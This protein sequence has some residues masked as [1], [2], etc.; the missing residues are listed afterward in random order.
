MKKSLDF[1]AEAKRRGSKIACL[2]AYDYPTARLLDEAGLDILLVGDSLG[3]VVLGHPDTTRVRMSDMLHH[4]RAVVRGTARAIV[5]ADLP[6][7]SCCTPDDAQKN[8]SLLAEAGA[9]AVKIE[10]GRDVVPMVRAI[11]EAGVPVFGHVGMLPQRVL[12]E[13][14][15][16][17]KGRS[18]TE[19]EAL[20]ADAESLQDAGACAIVLELVH[21]PVAEKITSSL[22][23]P[24]IGI[25][26]GAACDGQ[27]LVV[28]DLIGLFPWFRP[29]F[30]RPRADIAS[31][32]RHAAKAFVEAT[33]SPTT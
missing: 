21:P 2:T 6:S 33:R 29:K 32:I 7:G 18:E 9:D 17:I 13:G 8:A 14:G 25:G 30:A 28:H 10:G 12:K 23:I 4:T 24:T 5:L 19:S 20:L 22:A 11:R 26:S 16:K 1:L 31:E 27:V 15:Y 3:M